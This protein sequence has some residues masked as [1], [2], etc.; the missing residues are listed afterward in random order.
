MSRLY[1]SKGIGLGSS[2]VSLVTSN[3]ASDATLSAGFGSLSAPWPQNNLHEQRAERRRRAA[4]SGSLK[5]P[6]EIR[7]AAQPQQSMLL[8]GTGTALPPAIAA[9]N[10]TLQTVSAADD[11]FRDVKR[12]KQAS[13]P[14]ATADDVSAA[15]VVV[16]QSIHIIA[17]PYQL[18]DANIRGFSPIILCDAGRFTS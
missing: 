4:G 5:G 6:P 8:A 12:Q 1:Q 10:A 15:E 18:L 14:T 13:M 7:M 3:R 2:G 9:G 16:F 11:Y 17:W